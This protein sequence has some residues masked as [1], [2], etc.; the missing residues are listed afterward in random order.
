MAAPIMACFIVTLLL[1]T[2]VA[3][4]LATSLAPARHDPVVLV[5]T[6]RY[7]YHHLHTDLIRI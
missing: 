2:L 5:Q 7:L 3:H 6:D 4:E 1:D